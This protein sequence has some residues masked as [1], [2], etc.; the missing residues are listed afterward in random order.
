MV[1]NS[2]PI[3]TLLQ[4][5]LLIVILIS[6]I[7]FTEVVF[8]NVVNACWKLWNCCLKVSLIPGDHKPADINSWF[9]QAVRKN[10]VL[11]LWQSFRCELEL[12]LNC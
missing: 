6:C 5:V 4:G 1:L 12:V 3:L 7:R 10:A 2:E 9:V 11:S 8:P